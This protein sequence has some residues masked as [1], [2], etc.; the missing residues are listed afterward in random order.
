MKFSPKT[1]INRIQKETMQNSLHLLFI[2][3]S[4]KIFFT[5]LNSLDH[6]IQSQIEHVN[7][8]ALH[9]M[10]CIVK[11]LF[12]EKMR[13]KKIIKM[14]VCLSIHHVYKIYR[15]TAQNTQTWGEGSENWK[16][17][18]KIECLKLRD[19]CTCICC[20]TFFSLA[21]IMWVCIR[22]CT[23]LLLFL[24]FFLC[25]IIVTKWHFCIPNVS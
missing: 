5:I 6:N 18:L 25:V 13:N 1:L 10:N 8:L 15:T 21:I 9:N 2:L 7:T 23:L 19:A 11:L 12:E 22:Q 4:E 3:Y 17:K 20:C 24:R 16:K 14:N